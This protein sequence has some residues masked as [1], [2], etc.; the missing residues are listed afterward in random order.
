MRLRLKVNGARVCL[1]PIHGRG[2]FAT[3]N[4]DAD[5]LITL[6]PGD[7]LRFH[8]ADPEYGGDAHARNGHAHGF[9]FG[10]HVEAYRKAVTSRCNATF[11]GLL[12]AAVAV[13]ATKPIIAGEEI[14]ASY[15]FEYWLALDKLAAIS[16]TEGLSAT[17][18]A[19][20]SGR[21]GEQGERDQKRTRTE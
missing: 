4:I 9:I 21:C 19:E 16:R 1:S 17:G 5:E 13:I 8:L 20:A 12:D 6:Y 11:E 18:S 10:H 15:G 2:V 3:R 14:L 7:A